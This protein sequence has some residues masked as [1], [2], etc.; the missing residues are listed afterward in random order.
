MS[1]TRTALERAR[2]ATSSRLVASLINEGLVQAN[3]DSPYTAVVN[4]IDDSGIEYKLFLS[5]VSPV[6]VGNLQSLDPADIV[7]FHIYDEN[8]NEFLCPVTIADR[9]WKGCTIDLKQQLMSSV[10]NQEWIYNHLPAKTPSLLSS[11]IEWEQYIIEGHPTHP[12]HRTGIPFDGFESVL[13]APSIKFI[14]IPRSDMAING[15]WESIMKEYLPSTMSP[16]TIVLPVHELQVAKVL[17]LMPS[18][19][20]YS[21]FERKA[22]A[23]ASLRSIL[24]MPASDLPGYH[25]KMALTILTT[26]AWRTISCFSV[27]NGPRITPLAKFIAPDCLVI[28]GEIASIGSNSLDETNSKH[29]ACIVRE[30]PEVLMPD[31]SIIVV[32]CLIEKTPDGS[33]SLVRAIF[34]LDTEEKCVDFLRKYAEL[35]CAAFLPPMLKHGFC[36]EAHG[37]NTLAR[38]DQ[39][40]GQ[41][42][43]FAIRDFGGVRI[44]REQFESTTPFKLDVLPDSCIVTDDIMEVYTK[45]F[46]CFIQGQMNRLVRALD[47]HYSHKGWTIVRQAV[48]KHVSISSPAGR[49]WFK[50][51]VPYK[52]FLKMKL[53]HKYRDYIYSEVPNLLL[54]TENDKICYSF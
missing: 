24:P 26:G 39:H 47:L 19:T 33:M 4:C 35:A 25:L 42:I 20:L 13:L 17:S 27:Y 49:L 32:Q 3:A 38:F 46:H 8:G 21:N 31:E 14:S 15:N 43:G 12:M 30:D 28:I 6:S 34:H 41:L 29:I 50:E 51:T 48:E 37:Q 54:L 7:P 53:E 36:F 2:F 5:L 23:Q 52:A 44:H 1:L 18:A 16:D 10:R 45:V 9:F 40:T 11:A 22:L